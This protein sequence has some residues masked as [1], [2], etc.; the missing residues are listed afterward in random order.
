MINMWQDRDEKSLNYIDLSLFKV[1]FKFAS[2]CVYR[3]IALIPMT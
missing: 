2:I 1:A 3:C